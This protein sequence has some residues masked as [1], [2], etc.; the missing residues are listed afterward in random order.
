MGQAFTIID[1]SGWL[2]R[3]YAETREEA[4]SGHAALYR[5]PAGTRIFAAEH[6]G[7]FINGRTID[8]TWFVVGAVI[9]PKEGKE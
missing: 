5:L 1:G 7:N 8:G 4:A 9:D 3:R 6:D 2:K